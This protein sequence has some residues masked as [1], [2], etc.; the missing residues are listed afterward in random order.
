MFGSKPLLHDDLAIDMGRE[1]PISSAE[2]HRPREP[3]LWRL[4]GRRPNGKKVIQE[5]GIDAKQMMGTHA[6]KHTRFGR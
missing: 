2:K 6:G 5:G 1:H 3:S 4:P